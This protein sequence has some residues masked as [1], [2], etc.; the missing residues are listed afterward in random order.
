M[1]C[2]C[3]PRTCRALF[4]RDRLDTEVRGLREPSFLRRPLGP[5][6]RAGFT[7]TPTRK[8]PLGSATTLSDLLGVLALRLHKIKVLVSKVDFQFGSPGTTM[9]RMEKSLHRALSS[10]SPLCYLAKR[11]GQ[12]THPTQAGLCHQ[13][14]DGITGPGWLVLFM[15]GEVLSNTGPKIKALPPL[16][17]AAVVFG[18]SLAEVAP[19]AVPASSCMVS[20]AGTALAG[21]HNLTLNN[22]SEDVR[23][24]RDKRQRTGFDALSSTLKQESLV[25]S[26]CLLSQHADIL[27]QWHA[28][29]PTL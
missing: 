22:R 16:P 26:T 25:R 20:S 1:P 24:L 13:D 10:A 28:Q 29:S 8:P 7:D 6:G 19:S 17:E 11:L 2:Q 5:G 4:G 14:Q 9:T 23:G 3:G 18:L 21:R 27:K 15:P 12:R